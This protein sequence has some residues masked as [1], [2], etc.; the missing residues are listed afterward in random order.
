MGHGHSHD[1]AVE[2]GHGHGGQPCAGQLANSF[3]A[4]MFAGSFG[5][6]LLHRYLRSRQLLIAPPEP[7]A[8]SSSDDFP[9]STSPTSSFTPHSLY[10]G[11]GAAVLAD[12][13]LYDLETT[14][15]AVDMIE[16]GAIVLQR[17]GM[18]PT[19]TST[20]KKEEEEVE[21]EEKKQPLLS[22]VSLVFFG[23]D[24]DSLCCLLIVDSSICCSRCPASLP[25]SPIVH[26]LPLP[27]TAF[28]FL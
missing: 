22:L 19:H 12:L 7:A 6:Y 13:V 25:R 5:Y 27:L 18:P 23:F 24:F 4:G 14:V 15:P 20:H 21:V 8:S 26:L 9:A 28:R 11:E 10:G 17:P 2:G 1:R 3:V 16:F